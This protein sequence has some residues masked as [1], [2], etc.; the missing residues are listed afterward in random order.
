MWGRQSYWRGRVGVGVTFAKP[1]TISGTEHIGTATIG[2]TPQV[3]LSERISLY[4][5]IAFAF[6]FKQHYGFDGVLLNNDKMIETINNPPVF[7]GSKYYE[8]YFNFYL[9]L[10]YYQKNSEK[11]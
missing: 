2:L 10:Y 6:R 11:S 1:E 4:S 9:G 8:G 7:E 3:K 5:D